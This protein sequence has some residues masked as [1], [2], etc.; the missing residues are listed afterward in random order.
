MLAKV[1]A[2]V[3]FGTLVATSAVAACDLAG[4]MR[5]SADRLQSL[6]HRD[7]DM[8]RAESSEGGHWDVYLRQD[9][10]LHTIVRKDFGETG[11][12]N[13]RASFRTADQFVVVAT[14]V[15]YR[16]P[17][18]S[19]ARTKIARSDAT[20]YLFCGNV[21]YAPASLSAEGGGEKA[22]AAAKSLKSDILLPP[23]VAPY[24]S[25]ARKDE[26]SRAD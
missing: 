18:A 19:G 7:V 10:T 14:D 13:L 26:K 8:T 2:G 4:L 24:L 15:R 25:R 16:E 3:G 21:V 12:R 9:G 20:V 6:Q 11:M 1:I 22:V 5:I 23:E 17:I